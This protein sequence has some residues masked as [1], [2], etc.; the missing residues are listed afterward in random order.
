MRCGV[1]CCCCVC[2]AELW[3]VVGVQILVGSSDVIG[4]VQLICALLFRHVD[5]R[6]RWNVECIWW[7]VV[8]C[9][10]VCGVCRTVDYSKC[11]IHCICACVLICVVE[12]WCWLKVWMCPCWHWSCLWWFVL[13]CH[14]YVCVVDLSTCSPLTY[15]LFIWWIV[16]VCYVVVV[17]RCCVACQCVPGWSLGSYI[18]MCVDL[19]CRC[20]ARVVGMFYAV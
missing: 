17:C 15:W 12:C 6:S 19:L 9:Y 8:T 16:M 10:M 4:L 1:F 18:V 13:T 11:N 2:V 14:V 5:V 20:V 3:Y 7:F